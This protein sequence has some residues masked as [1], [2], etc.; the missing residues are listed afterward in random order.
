M[1]GRLW[2]LAKNREGRV[3]NVEGNPAHPLSQGKICFR[4]QTGLQETYSPDR[5]N[6][7]SKGNAL[8]SWD[9]A[10]K[11]VASAS[12]GSVTWIG[13]PR[14]GASAALVKQ[15]VG[16]ALN[17]NILYWSELDNNTLRKATKAAFGV[18]GVPTFKLDD[19]HTILNFGSD[20][21]NAEGSV[22]LAQGWAKSKDPEQGGFVSKMF[23]VGP[24][25]GLTNTNTDIHISV[26]A[27][28]EAQLAYRSR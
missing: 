12:A 16:E 20:F 19:A 2:D 6:A 11:T 9:D 27:G 4:G 28:T 17:G 14:T 3:L 26:K 10:L 21:L 5:L 24:R 22:S 1:F 23:S 18:D 25:I 15:F 7:P 13:R 8:V